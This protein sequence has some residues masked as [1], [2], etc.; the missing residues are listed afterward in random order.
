FERM[1]LTGA[2]EY[3]FTGV[4][5]SVAVPLLQRAGSRADQI[6]LRRAEPVITADV[7]V[8]G[9]GPGA[10]RAV[11]TVAEQVTGP[12]TESGWRVPGADPLP[13]LE[14]AGLPTGSGLPSAATIEALQ[15]TW[16]DVAR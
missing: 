8:V 5:E 13:Q 2:A 7:V 1:L 16:Q 11:E 10:Q 4:L 14:G 3:E 12:L 9:Y 6:V 15:Q